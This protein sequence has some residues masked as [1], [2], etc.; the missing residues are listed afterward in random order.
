LQQLPIDVVKI[1]RRFV[2]NMLDN[3]ED[4]AI[5]EGVL[6][7]AQ[8]LPR[9]VLAEGVESLEI[10]QLLQQIGCQYAQGYGIARPMPA[11]QVLAWLCEWAN[12]RCWHRGG[13]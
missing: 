5:V 4:R 6:H 12:D 11:D 8:T 1:D 7:M 13:H 3:A 10:G 9:P 2:L